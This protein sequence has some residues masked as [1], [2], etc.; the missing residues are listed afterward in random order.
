[1]LPERPRRH[2]VAKI[3]G[4]K[5]ADTGRLHPVYIVDLYLKNRQRKPM[6]FIYEH[7]DDKKGFEVDDHNVAAN[8]PYPETDHRGRFTFDFDFGDYLMG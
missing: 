2:F 7:K 6:T 3:R 8:L 1:M 4:Q 5:K